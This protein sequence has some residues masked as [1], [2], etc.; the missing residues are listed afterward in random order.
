MR[1]NRQRTRNS[2]LFII[3]LT[4]IFASVAA[5]LSWWLQPDA[6]WQPR[7]T[8]FWF[9]GVWVSSLGILDTLA[10]A[11]GFG[12]RALYGDEENATTGIKTESGAVATDGS[13]AVG[14]GAAN[15]SGDVGRDLIV[16]QQ[17][18]QYITN[19][20]GQ[21]IPWQLPPRPQNFTGRETE[22]AWVAERVQ[23]GQMFSVTAAGGMGKT[24]LVAETVWQLDTAGVLR[25]RFPDGVIFYSFYGQ[26]A[27]DSALTHMLESYGVSSSGNLEPTVRYGTVRQLLGGKRALLLLD[28]TEVADKL[29]DLLAVCGT[30]GVSI[31]TR[32]RRPATADVLPL[33]RLDAD[34]ALELL[35]KWAG[36]LAADERAARRIVALVGG[37]PLA[38][39]LVGLYL[40]ETQQR[41]AE[42]RTWLEQSPMAALDQG[43]RRADSVPLLL[44]R[45]VARLSS[46]AQQIVPLVGLL[47]LQ[48]FDQRLIMAGL[49][50]DAA[51]L[52]QPLGE[53]VRFGLLDRTADGRWRVA[54]ALVH[55]YAR[56]QPDAQRLTLLQALADFL[57]GEVRRERERGL[58]GYVA[59]DAL[60]VHVM[61]LLAQ[62]E[63]AAE[64]R[65]VDRLVWAIEDYLDIRG[66]SFER[67]QALIMA[68]QACREIGDRRGEGN[69]LGNLGNAYRNLG[70][71]ERAIDFYQQALTISRDIGDRRGEGADL[72]NLGIAYRNLG[73]VERAIELMEASVKI[74]DEIKSPNAE[75]ARG[76]L[77]DVRNQAD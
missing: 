20:K 14:A 72:G 2:L 54:H 46:D 33:E 56:T 66:H 24:A 60:R 61:T 7:Q 9:V 73:E 22:G 57:N 12:E 69:H 40:Q 28:G 5:L 37:L 51:A 6:E 38:V 39:R 29:P 48:P 4:T 62:L 58:E 47:A 41:V 11:M 17:V 1:R 8:F 35:R 27:V 25:E 34:R 63:E 74:F 71:V 36:V 55:T 59:I 52:R 64:W 31:T 26:P 30:C 13:V 45:S 23:P 18:T 77:A 50:S 49:G 19:A 75:V 67:V 68:V 10:G 3:G 44:G 76:W 32:D 15:V 21:R 70:E 42:Y 53:L 16:A 43:K 65:R